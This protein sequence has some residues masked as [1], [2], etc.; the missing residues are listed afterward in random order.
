MVKSLY[1]GHHQ[2]SRPHEKSPEHD[3]N[4]EPDAPAMPG[5]ARCAQ[6]QKIRPDQNHK[7]PTGG[8]YD[9][10]GRHTH[11][12]SALPEPTSNICRDYCPDL[13][14]AFPIDRTK[15][16]SAS[17]F[18]GLSTRAKG[19]SRYITPRRASKNPQVSC[20]FLQM[21]NA[22]NSQRK[23]TSKH[24]FSGLKCALTVYSE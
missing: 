21:R 7:M 12:D 19:A 2:G 13:Q 23:R 18:R 6:L 16:L 9:K 24:W 14:N 1:P 5:W 10:H 8:T 17:S 22:H 4:N 3:L 20:H 15:T 11:Q